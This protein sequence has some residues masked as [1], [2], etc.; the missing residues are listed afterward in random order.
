MEIRRMMERGSATA[1]RSYSLSSHLLFN[2]RN[3]LG[4][5]EGKIRPDDEKNS[6]ESDHDGAVPASGEDRQNSNREKHQAKNQ[7][8]DSIPP[9]GSSG[10]LISRLAPLDDDIQILDIGFTSGF[11]GA[12]GSHFC[13]AVVTES[14]ATGFANGDA[15]SLGMIEAF[16]GFTTI[17]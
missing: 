5:H 4:I 10:F 16:H 11:A 12:A 6:Q 2:V 8:Q 13:M 3:L 17:Q 15:V 1:V 9:V 7:H 14:P